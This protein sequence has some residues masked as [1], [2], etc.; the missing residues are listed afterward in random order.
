[1]ARKYAGK[2]R[3]AFKIV[4]TEKDEKPKQ[5]YFGTARWRGRALFRMKM[6]LYF[7]IVKARIRLSQKWWTYSCS[8]RYGAPGR[9]EKIDPESGLVLSCIQQHEAIVCRRYWFHCFDKSEE[10][11]CW[12]HQINE[13]D[14]SPW[15]HFFLLRLIVTPLPKLSEQTRYEE[16]WAEISQDVQR[17]R[18]ARLFK[19]SNR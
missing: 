2:E 9:L 15:L 18:A 12:L 5:V 1:M 3:W 16:N 13:E 4:L 7:Q 6:L 10:I 14:Y 19:K 8:V 17:V 11:F